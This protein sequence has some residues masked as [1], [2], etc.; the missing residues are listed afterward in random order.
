MMM[1]MVV[2]ELSAA[3]YA[4]AVDKKSGATVVS[5][6]D[7][8]ACLGYMRIGMGL[9]QIRAVTPDREVTITKQ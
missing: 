8:I 1:M 9:P 2:I 5:V 4:T 3:P 6:S 7:I